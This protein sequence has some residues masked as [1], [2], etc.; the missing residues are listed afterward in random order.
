MVETDPI[1]SYVYVMNYVVSW[2]LNWLMLYMRIS[3]RA[4][5]KVEASCVVA[6]DVCNLGLL[7]PYSLTGTQPSMAWCVQGLVMCILDTVV[8]DLYLYWPKY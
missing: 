8:N 5:Q 4:C 6:I 7:E 2:S 3:R 1:V